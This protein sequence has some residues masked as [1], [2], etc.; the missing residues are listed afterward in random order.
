MTITTTK[1]K[2]RTIVNIDVLNTVTA[3][4]RAAYVKRAEEV[5]MSS[6]VNMRQLLAAQGMDLNKVAPAP[7]NR[8]SRKEY[9]M[10][11]AAHT[12][13]LASFTAA[14]DA[15]PY[16]FSARLNGTE[17]WI[18]VEKPGAE[19][20]VREEARKAANF[21]FD[22]YLC[23]LAGKIE[24]QVATA[25][26]NGNLWD[27]STLCVTCTDGENQ[28]WFTQCIMNQSVYGKLFNQWPTRRVE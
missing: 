15:T 11:Q 5:F 1:K 13:Y 17:P 24:K 4:H 10:R 3:D 14:P 27:G 9:M 16:G 19:A 25:T 12:H 22:S 2:T 28:T 6:L 7:S 23:K 20:K 21:N 8:L 18:V 26:L